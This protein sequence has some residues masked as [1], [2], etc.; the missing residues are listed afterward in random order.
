MLLREAAEEGVEKPVRM[1]G[2]MDGDSELVLSL[3]AEAPMPRCTGGGSADDVDTDSGASSRLSV[4]V[5]SASAAKEMRMTPS[6]KP[7]RSALVALASSSLSPT[8]NP[9]DP[10]REDESSDD[11]APA[12]G[13]RR[14]GDGV[15]C[16]GDRGERPIFISG[17]G[18]CRVV[19][20]DEGADEEPKEAGDGDTAML[21]LIPRG[22]DRGE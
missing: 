22:R 16:I 5:S 17:I 20:D 3:A 8:A 4:A 2:V 1:G 13:E 15:D 19:D 7:F 11:D 21:P 12:E 6:L 18:Y 9:P 10:C 14:F